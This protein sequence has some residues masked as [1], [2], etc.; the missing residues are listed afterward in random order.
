VTTLL[1]TIPDQTT[2]RCDLSTSLGGVPAGCRFSL[3]RKLLSRSITAFTSRSRY[4]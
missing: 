4:Y 3:G 2:G 1:V